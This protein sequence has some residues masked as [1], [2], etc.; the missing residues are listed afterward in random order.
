MLSFVDPT[1]RPKGCIGTGDLTNKLTAED[2]FKSVS[3]CVKQGKN[4]EGALLLAMA[5]TYGW[6]DMLRVSDTSARSAFIALNM[7]VFSRMTPEQKKT[8]E[9]TVEKNVRSPEGLAA[10]CNEIKRIGPPDYIPRYMIEHGKALK[11]ADDW[12]VKDFNADQVWK[13]SLQSYLHCAN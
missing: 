3:R 10:T 9:E 8:F 5:G 7:G 13:Q 12:L 6:F 11:N 4:K 1:V 2:L